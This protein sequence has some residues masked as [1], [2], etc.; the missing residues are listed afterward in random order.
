MRHRLYYLLP[1]I[2][3]A[4]RTFDDLLLKR[5]EQRYVHFLAAG[6]LPSDLPEANFLHKTDIVRGAEAGMLVGAV[7][8]MGLG[9]IIVLYFDMTSEALVVTTSTLVGVLF[10]GW[11]AS[12]VAAAIPNTRLKDFYPEIE[13]GKVLMIAD[14]PARRVTEIE[15][16]LAERH[17]E[18]RFRGEEPTIPVF[19]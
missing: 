19:P 2:E 18:M 14:I 4:R 13:K 11:A 8:G 3:C 7:L 5:I 6:T 17:P 10:G 1:D 9:A 15:S 16:V 12:L